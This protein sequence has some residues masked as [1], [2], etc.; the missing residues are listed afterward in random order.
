MTASGKDRDILARTLGGEGHAGAETRWLRL[1]QGAF[2]AGGCVSHR[3]HW[4][5][6]NVFGLWSVVSADCGTALHVGATERFG[7]T[8]KK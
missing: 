6:L 8:Q 1:L 4:L 2:L 7:F 3:L 5:A